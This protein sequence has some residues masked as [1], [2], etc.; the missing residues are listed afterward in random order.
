LYRLFG[1]KASRGGT[2][3]YRR[4]RAALVT[5]PD[6]LRGIQKPIVQLES[7]NEVKVVVFDSANPDYFIS[8]L[9]LLRSGKIDLSPGPTGISPWPDFAPRLAQIPVISV[10][11]IRGRARGVG[12]EVVLATDV[13]FASREKAIFG[14]FEIGDAAM[15]GRDGLE[16]L[17][18]LMGR[19]RALEAIVG[20]DDFDADTAERYG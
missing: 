1:R 13:R 10:A 11:A 2:G 7:D 8:H 3:E 16:R 20:G 4:G 5:D 19:A 18:L 17:H 14:Q 6:L 9:D 12:N 15:P